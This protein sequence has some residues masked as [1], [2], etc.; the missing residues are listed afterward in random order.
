MN[1]MMTLPIGEAVPGWPDHSDCKL[2][3][4]RVEDAHR[5]ALCR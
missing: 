5:W 1:P 2:S 3:R 4:W